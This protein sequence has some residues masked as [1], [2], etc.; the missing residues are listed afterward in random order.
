MLGTP[1]M[2]LLARGAGGKFDMNPRPSSSTELTPTEEQARVVAAPLGPLRV[3]AAAGTGKTTTIALRVAELVRRHAIAPEEILGLTFTNKA[4]EELADRIRRILSQDPAREVEV[5]TY[6]GFAASLLREFGPL[7]GIERDT[8]IITPAFTRQLLA[9]LLHRVP[10]DVFDPT[11]YSAVED[12]RR[13][14]AALADN[15]LTPDEVASAA[16]EGEPWPERLEM[17]EILRRY[18]ESKRRLGVTDY[19]DLIFK[20][21]LLVRDHPRV[22]ET[23]RS[24]YRTVLLDE[25]QDTN[26]AQRELLRVLFAQRVPV[27]A[28]GDEY[29]TIYEWRGASPANFADFP[30]HFPTSTGPAP[31]AYLTENRRS[32][33]EILRVANAIIDELGGHVHLRPHP[34]APPARVR[35]GWF[36]TA[37][38]EAEWLAE[39]IVDRHEHGR[40]WRDMAIL[41]RKNKDMAVVHHALARRRIP[42]EV[43]NLGGL[44]DVPEIVDLHAWLR[45]IERPDDGP[46][47][48]RILLGPRYRLGLADLAPL[49]D[50]ARSRNLDEVPVGLLE[51]VDRLEEVEGLR[52]EAREAL[53]QFR[54]EYLDLVAAA[55]RLSLVELSRA[56]LDRT[57]VWD[58]IEAA[59]PSAGLSARLNLHRFLDLAQS[60]SP[61]EGRSTLG[62][63]LAHLD[64]L[65]EESGE[66]LDTARLSGADAVTLIT[67]HRAKGLEWPIVFLPAVYEGNF[68]NTGRAF[69]DPNR[70]A[71]VLPYELRLDADR[72][73]RTPDDRRETLRRVRD[74]EEWR[75]AYVAVTRAKEELFLTGAYW[76]GHPVPLKTPKRPSPLWRLAEGAGARPLGPMP[77]VPERPETSPVRR[78]T[79]PPPDPP[80]RELLRRA[81]DDPGLPR[82][83]AH[84]EG[85]LEAYDREVESFRQ[86]LLG[87]TEPAPPRSRP[88]ETSATGLVTY[89]GCP[90]RYYWSEVDRLP[91]RSGWAARRG[92]EVHRRIEL[93]LSGV[94]PLEDLAPD[95]YDTAEG[96]WEGE[97][98]PGVDPYRVFL[99]SRFADRK[100]LLVETPFQLRLGDATIRGRIDAVYDHG[101]R[102]EVVDFKSGRRPPDGT[103]LVQLQVYALAVRDV[104]FGLPSPETL[105][106]TFAYLGG[107]RLEEVT[108]L[109]DAAW[110]EEARSRVEEL[111]G[112]I[113]EERWDPKPS[114]A[115]R[116]C[117]FLR[118]CPAG[119]RFSEPPPSG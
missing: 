5:Y 71:R 11:G 47:L 66:E 43:A 38:D 119:R 115:C 103:P 32:G 21:Y 116:S 14:A 3:A 80:W 102:W 81:V 33:P 108:H 40:R 6:H 101:D 106:V 60:W 10:C 15:L 61:L 68:P 49:T 75:I 53:E 84:R 72:F 24:R 46:A 35:L 109:A 4:A 56:I 19:G 57:G 18:E 104:S 31:T 89:A 88:V 69:D 50:W 45:I 94:V 67:V 7:I 1:R 20:A 73:P 22:A 2:S 48:A 83:M 87:L 113:E 77:E 63:F 8:P 23:V 70:L 82:R 27:M 28:V 78:D 54:R 107:S 58:E 79:S 92:V 98:E 118:F 59:E 30:D 52:V 97:V 99:G 76:Y 16:G 29:Q 39:T 114:A 112:G 96:G 74:E 93:H 64:A 12:L 90:R 17:L 62:A 42:F 85:L 34:E 37:A 26:P 95:L 41:F 51:A 44:L 25:Y 86:M 9:D 36:P 13:L 65:S 55:Q 110:L 100:P 105:Q 91:R 111:I 117:D